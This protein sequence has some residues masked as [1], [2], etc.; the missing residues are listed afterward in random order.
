MN[1]FDRVKLSMDFKVNGEIIKSGTVGTIR[2]IEDD[3]YLIQ[4][5]SEEKRIVCIPDTML[6]KANIND[7]NKLNPNYIVPNIFKIGTIWHIFIGYDD[8][9]NK[10]LKPGVIANINLQEN[11]EEDKLTIVFEDQEKEYI[12]KFL[13]N[14]CSL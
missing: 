12:K 3:C 2:N 7:L 8:N 10:V 13:V 1:I 9:S 5:Y 6:I 4:I 11:E 14:H